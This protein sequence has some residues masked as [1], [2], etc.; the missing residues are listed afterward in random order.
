MIRAAAVAAL[1]L[2]L[3]LTAVRAEDDP[4]IDPA[5][6]K[7]FDG[8]LFASTAPLGNK[9]TYAC[10]VRRYDAAHLA[11]HPQQKVGAMKIL[12][13]GQRPPEDAT[14]A[15]SFRL[16]VK[17]RQRAADFDSSGY[18]NHAIAT[19][20]GGEMGLGCGVECDG[21]GLGV[22]LSGD[23][24]SVVVHLERLRIWKHRGGH[25]EDGED[26]EAGADD[27]AFRLERANL[28]ECAPLANDRKEVAAL[29]RQQKAS[30]G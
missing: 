6:A 17:F 3:G 29:K 25:P 5:K 24:K 22:A 28:N 26:L 15:Y 27:K 7:A 16:G 10:F 20:A 23:D 19:E 21:G 4:P 2:T 12:V 14:N 18:C 9:P 11:N 8:R 1:L 13:S 30:G